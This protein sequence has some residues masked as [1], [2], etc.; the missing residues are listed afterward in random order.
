[1]KNKLKQL[2]IPAIMTA[3]ISLF[4]LLGGLY[5][6][7][8]AVSDLLYQREEALDGNVVII[9]YDEK[10]LQELWRFQDWNRDVWAEAINRLNRG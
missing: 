3:A 9:G 6:P 2:I 8:N 1:M 7:D 10:S 5:A 4:C